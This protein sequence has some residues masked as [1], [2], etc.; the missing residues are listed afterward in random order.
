[1]TTVGFKI[2]ERGVIVQLQDIPYIGRDEI[3]DSDM[4]VGGFDGGGFGF[5]PRVSWLEIIYRRATNEIF[6]IGCWDGERGGYMPEII[7]RP[8]P[9]HITI[10]R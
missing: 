3:V 5:G 7:S 9:T 10:I 1:M 8:L 2:L 4:S 6:K